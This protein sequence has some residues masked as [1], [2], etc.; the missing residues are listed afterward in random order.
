MNPNNVV[1]AKTK[2]SSCLIRELFPIFNFAMKSNQMGE[3]IKGQN[4]IWDLQFNNHPNLFK[5][6]GSQ[7]CFSS[8]LDSLC[9][10]LFWL[11]SQHFK[12]HKTSKDCYNIILVNVLVNTK[13][14][15]SLDEGSKFPLGL[16][17]SQS[18]WTIMKDHYM[19]MASITRANIEESVSRKIVDDQFQS[20]S[21]LW[22]MTFCV[23]LADQI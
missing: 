5:W 9:L 8:K 15:G 10:T 6:Y 2:Q 12:S 21:F 11:P 16:S 23:S 17:Q 14:S 3:K 1:A 7:I 19:N 22:R 20:G 4:T 18:Q 13:Y